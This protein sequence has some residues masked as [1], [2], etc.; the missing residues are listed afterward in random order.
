VVLGV[1]AI[2]FAVGAF[3]GG[4]GSKA[5]AASGPS[6][7]AAPATTAAVQEP[8]APSALPS[9]AASPSA[10]SSASASRSASAE[11]EG[12]KS[13]SAS[14]SPTRDGGGTSPGPSASSGGSGGGGNGGN[15][16]GSG[17]GGGS[18]K[19]PVLREGDSG[20]AVVDLQ[21]R[22]KRSSCLCYLLGAEDGEYDGAVKDAVSSYQRGHDIKGDPDGVYGPNT[23]RALEAETS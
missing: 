6:H 16:G 11:A 7:G 9:S 1:A 17:G 19:P 22:L 12:Q 5:G 23:R 15:G 20:P 14:A 13:P 8:G 21:K 2:A 4:G 18:Q 10:S 3:S